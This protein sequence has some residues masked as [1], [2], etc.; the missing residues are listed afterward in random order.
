MVNSTCK[1]NAIFYNESEDSFLDPDILAFDKLKVIFEDDENDG[2]TFLPREINYKSDIDLSAPYSQGLY[3]YSTMSSCPGTIF[4][5]DDCNNDLDDLD[6]VT[7]LL[8][9]DVL[10]LIPPDNMEQVAATPRTSMATSPLVCVSFPSLA[11][12][13]IGSEGAPG[14][15]NVNPSP[16]ISQALQRFLTTSEHDKISEVEL[17]SLIAPEFKIPVDKGLSIHVVDALLRFCLNSELLYLATQL[18]QHCWSKDVPVSE[19]MA[20]ETMLVL[21]ERG[22][23]RCI[24]NLFAN[25]PSELVP[26]VVSCCNNIKLAQR[27]MRVVDEMVKYKM[28]SA[29]VR[30]LACIKCQ[31]NDKILI[32]LSKLNCFDMLEDSA[33]HAV[34][35]GLAQSN[36]PECKGQLLELLTRSGKIADFIS[37]MSR[38]DPSRLES[39]AIKL[40]GAKC[41]R[42]MDFIYTLYTLNKIGPVD[43]V[44]MHAKS[45]L[46]SIVPESLKSPGFGNFD[47]LLSLPGIKELLDMLPPDMETLSWPSCI[48]ML[49][50]DAYPSLI[51]ACLLIADLETVNK[52]LE[53]LCGILDSPP[54]AIVTTILKCMCLWGKFADVIIRINKIRLDIEASN[55]NVAVLERIDHIVEFGLRVAMSTFD[56]QAAMEF[57][58]LLKPTQKV[59]AEL[60]AFIQQLAPMLNNRQLSDAFCTTCENLCLDEAAFAAILDCCMRYKNTKRLLQ[61]VNK[62]KNLS[63]QPQL[64]TYGAIIKALGCCG[65]INECKRVWHEMT[66]ERGFEPNEVTYGI[67]LDALV[68]NNGLMDAMALFNEMKSKGNVKP[69]TIMY[70]TLIKGFGQNKQLGR[71]MKIYDIMCREQIERNTVTYNSIINACARAGDMKGATA[72]L[73]DMLANGVEPDV[74][75]FSTI[76]KGYCIQSDMDRSFQLL[77]IMYERGIMP[78]G[79]LYNSLL[80]GCVKSGR[81]WLCEMLWDQ[82]QKHEIPP[83]N[84]TLTI[85]IKMYG[86]SGQLDKVFEL[87]GRLPVEY[88]FT[89][90]AHVYTCLM[91]ACISNQRYSMALDIYDCMKNAA[92]KPDAKT[93]ETLIQGATRGSLFKKIVS[94]INDLYNPSVTDPVVAQGVNTKLV[95]NLFTR[96]LHADDATANLYKRLARRLEKANKLKFA[97]I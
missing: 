88:N 23:F 17:I 42:A 26:C 16:R 85:L 93:F 40:I 64:Q 75:T 53:N 31:D 22:S 96:A 12:T 47:V 29:I 35:L 78:D 97:T 24:S 82:M 76:I 25:M 51:E 66:V 89:I 79:I 52:V 83:S 86:R 61:L 10:S 95:Y 50:R 48:T 15:T 62:L 8:S 71:A 43:D 70:T 63:T 1:R 57:C 56:F 27:L 6:N 72:L 4:N 84:F 13:P 94:I 65:R 20:V 80:E 9:E 3:S 77:G 74:I 2:K 21:C 54:L 68:N 19:E 7:N 18:L 34:M 81:L 39:V 55:S 90:N 92:I 73:E 44:L 91:S 87:V 60:S 11:T 67:M 30:E 38:H 49:E 32:G 58:R 37:Y 36:V 5:I 69:N 59:N 41:M 45:A 46:V 33:K 28:A 14:L